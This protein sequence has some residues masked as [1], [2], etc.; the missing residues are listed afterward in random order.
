MDFSSFIIV[1]D[2]FISYSRKDSTQAF[3]LAE[4]L[5]ANGASVW[6]DQSNIELATNWSR[7]I[8]EAIDGCKVVILLL[9][10]SSIKSHNV[11]KEVS[12]A[13]E[14]RKHLL[15]LELEEVRL[16]PELEYALAGLQRSKYTN[17]DSITKALQRFGISVGESQPAALPKIRETKPS[18]MILPFEDLSPTGDNGWFTDG[19]ASELAS[20]LGHVKSLRVIDWNTSQLFKSRK[21]KTSDLAR[22]LEV[23]Y[24]VEGQVR[25]FEQQIRIV[26]SL[27]DIETG[28]HL[29]Q[30]SLRGTM[31]DV[32]DIQETVASKVVGGLK[33]HLTSIEQAK[34]RESRTVSSE[35]YEL[36]LRA[37]DYYRKQ[38]E[39]AFRLAIEQLTQAIALDP[40]Y[41]E[42][43][44][45]KAVVL[46]R[47][48]R[49][50]DRNAYY[51]EEAERL[52]NAALHIAPDHWRTHY[53]LSTVYLAS[54]KFDEAEN[55]A[56]ASVKLAPNESISHFG[57]GFFYSQKDQPREALPHYER[58]IELMPDDFSS[59]W[60]LV[61]NANRANDLVRSKKWSQLALP[62]YER[63][64]RLVPDDHRR[65]LQYATLLHLS[66]ASGEARSSLQRIL[67][68]GDLEAGSLYNAACL[69]LMLGDH[70][71][72]LQT[73]IRAVDAGFIEVEH[74]ERDSV[75]DPIRERPEFKAMI[76]RLAGRTNVRK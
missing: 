75:L 14:R 39:G 26:I 20:A 56:K 59:Y 57:L 21:I 58:A 63:Y 12:L 37:Q 40:T 74:L 72:A 5:R 36:H 13:S 28:E 15:P 68:G 50:F 17:T 42:A 47:L 31:E 45:L 24:F 46:A 34:L 3:A 38:T 11:I 18:L 67:E 1:P 6:I 8:V 2:I 76:E 19:M 25:K 66:G 64:L 62:H 61:M 27:L 35:A 32:F 10:S 52:A 55:A 16:P 29:W 4:Q 53:A 49:T 54:E 69:Y 30:D 33:L 43:M 44:Q 71:L 22:E 51:I 73:L 70:E 23:R 41:V 65:R 60:N 9:S 48:F 7:E